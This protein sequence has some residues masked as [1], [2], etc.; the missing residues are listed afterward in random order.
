VGKTIVNPPGLARPSGF[1]H[2]IE[3]SGRLLFLAGQTAQDATGRIVAR[4]DLVGQFR[5]AL[6]NVRTVVG[7]RGGT[8]QDLVKVTIFVRD[9][10]DYRA[11]ARDIGEVY[12]E[13]LG[14][15]YPAATLLEVSALWDD[16]ALI[17][18][19]G[20]AV[21]EEPAPMGDRGR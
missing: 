9:K 10:A 7:A 18:I 16:D 20:I 6:I 21:L 13:L 14:G 12:R 8:L 5:Q 11:R 17:E 2:G 15:H 4:G 19:D 1:S 3:T